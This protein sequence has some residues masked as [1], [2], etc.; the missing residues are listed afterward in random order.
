VH[1][2]IIEYPNLARDI[3]VKVTLVA[4]LLL[5]PVAQELYRCEYGALMSRT[6]V[7]SATLLRILIFS[8]VR[9]AFRSAYPDKE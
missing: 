3:R 5:T 4:R 7:H 9:E 2:R 6:C 8:A 1:M